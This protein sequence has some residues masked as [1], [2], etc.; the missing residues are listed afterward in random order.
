M[1]SRFSLVF[2]L[3]ALV[4]PGCK[5]SSD[6]AGPYANSIIIL[7]RTPCYGTCPVYKIQLEGNGI[8]FLENTRFV[9]PLGTF[10]GNVAKGDLNSLFHSFA[11]TDWEQYEDSYDANVSD[12]PTVKLTWYHSG[13][14]KEI[15]IRAKHPIELDVL[16]NKVD[17]VKDKIAWKAPE[18]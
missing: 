12:L 16:I 2:L 13:Y 5:T 10:K 3:I 18:L 4:L 1:R 9:E 8:A 7:E 17:Q 15:S 6:A 11:S 14:Q